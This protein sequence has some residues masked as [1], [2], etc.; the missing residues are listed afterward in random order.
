MN[1][2]V[3]IGNAAK[4]EVQ[5]LY[6]FQGLRLRFNLSRSRLQLRLKEPQFISRFRRTP[7]SIR[8]HIFPSPALASSADVEQIKR[9]F[10]RKTLLFYNKYPSVFFTRLIYTT[11]LS[12]FTHPIYKICVLRPFSPV[13]GSGVFP[14]FVLAF[15]CSDTS[16][17]CRDVGKLIPI[18]INC[19]K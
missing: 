16:V 1:R 10:L 19:H 8:N 13:F 3:F 11:I 12:C 4:P 14:C 2:K 18:K 6:I 5:G 9:R 15:S 17:P 7:K